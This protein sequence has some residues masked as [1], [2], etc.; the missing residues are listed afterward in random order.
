MPA[1]TCGTGLDRDLSK[2]TKLTIAPRF[3][4]G[5]I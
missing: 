1:S 2:S 4:L 5:E 3:G